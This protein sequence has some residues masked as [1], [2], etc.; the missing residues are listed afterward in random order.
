MLSHTALCDA[1][2]METRNGVGTQRIPVEQALDAIIN[3]MRHLLILQ[4]DRKEA[5][6]DSLK[7]LFGDSYSR[8]LD[9]I[10]RIGDCC[11]SIWLV[12]I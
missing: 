7:R 8:V 6:N 5:L 4:R 2:V 3:D 1:E 9:A 11:G 12:S 10:Q